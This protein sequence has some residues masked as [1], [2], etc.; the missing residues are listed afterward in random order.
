MNK[1][2]ANRIGTVHR[3]FIRDILKVTQRPEVIS[4]A[5]GLPNPDLFPCDKM[6]E[7]ANRVLSQWGHMALQ[8]STTEGHPP[9]RQ[10]IADRYRKRFSMD[11]DPDSLTVTTGSQQGLDLLAKALV[12]PGDKIIIEKPGYL[13]AIQA[14]SFFEP[15]FISIQLEDDGPNLAELEQA[16]KQNPKMYYA[17]PNFQNPSGI[18][19]SLE[20]RKAVAELLNKYDTIFVEDDPYGELRFSGQ[21]HPPVGFFAP[22]KSAMLGSFSKIAAPGLRLGW[23]YAGEWLATKLVTAK[24]ACDLHTPSITQWIMTD[25]LENNEIDDHIKL[26]IERYGSQC[27]TMLKAIDEH[28]P[29]GV[30]VIK[31]EGGM[32]VW[33]KLPEGFDTKEVFDQAIKEDVAF[34]PGFP[35][36]AE[37]GP[38]RTLRLNFSNSNEERIIEGISRLGKCFNQVLADQGQQPEG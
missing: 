19:Y 5:G 33:A 37:P 1:L 7:S 29:A 32:F 8:Y 24:Q 10:W 31:P 26:I 4:F 20:K 16:L 23:V 36:Y 17:V 35:F 15:E 30:K 3:S 11:V 22:E 13:G 9:L 34:V 2:F 25:F 27:E 21:S 28:F 6:A 38:R 18:S 14:F 12:N